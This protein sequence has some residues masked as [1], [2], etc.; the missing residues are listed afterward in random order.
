MD[1]ITALLDGPR[2]RGAFVLRSLL[3]PPWSIRI[4]DEAP[5]ALVAV[6]RGE[7]WIIHGDSSTRLAAGS[8]AIVRGPQHYT[9]ADTPTTP[10]DIVIHPGQRCETINGQSL[11]MSMRLGV[12]TW[13]NALDAPTAFITGIYESR[14][15][16]GTDLLE[17]L[18]RVVVVHHESRHPIAALL[19]D[20]IIRESP[21]QQAVLDRLLDILVIDTI[22]TWYQEQADSSAWW[23][24]HHD[25]LV[26]AALGL[27]HDSPEESWTISTLARTIGTSR[28]NLARRFND[29]VGE[30]PITYLTNWR[31]SLAAD[32][33]CQPM[34]TVAATARSVGYG[35]P[36]AFST[37]FKRRYGISP[38]QHRARASTR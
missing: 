33:L 11:A 34:S 4:C 1:R 5:L 17:T 28:A 27:M 6:T 19:A 12:R 37:A 38:H 35:S 26:G 30:P 24:A 20:E 8:I 13:G 36:F 31:L 23:D 9:V 32:L 25:P 7:A 22:R 14:T 2:A 21:G 18:P 3:V 15:T 10:P 16:L 29:L